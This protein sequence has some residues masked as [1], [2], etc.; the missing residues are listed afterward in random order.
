MIEFR[1]RV[2]RHKSTDCTILYSDNTS[3]PLAVTA[4]AHGNNAPRLKILSA[5]THRYTFTWPP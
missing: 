2:A 4:S 5:G 1:H 3:S